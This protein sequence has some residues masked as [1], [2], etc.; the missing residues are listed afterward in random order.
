MEDFENWSDCEPDSCA[1][2]RVVLDVTDVPVSPSLGVT[3]F[4]DVSSMCSDREI[5]EPQ[6]FSFSKK[7]CTFKNKDDAAYTDAK[8]VHLL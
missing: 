8:F 6:S 1:R 2:A 3:E 7:A 4:C 5:V